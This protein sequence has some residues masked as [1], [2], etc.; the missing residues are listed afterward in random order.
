MS[1][2]K[3]RLEIKDRF[4]KVMRLAIAEQWDGIDSEAAFADGI[5]IMPQ[6]L[7]HIKNQEGRNITTEMIHNLCKKF[8]VNAN[9]VIVGALPVKNSKSAAEKKLQQI[10]KILNK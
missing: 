7:S 2:E 6:Q 3:L 5:D 4:F 10:E 9:F 8:D 1:K